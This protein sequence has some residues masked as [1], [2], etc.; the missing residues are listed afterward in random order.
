MAASSTPVPVRDHR[1]AVGD[2]H[3]VEQADAEQELRIERRS[4][5][6]A[7]RESGWSDPRREMAVIA[8]VSISV[9]TSMPNKRASGIEL[10]GQAPGSCRCRSRFPARWRRRRA[11]RPADQ[12]VAA[13][14]IIPPR[15]VIDVTLPAVHPVH[16]AGRFGRP[17]RDQRRYPEEYC[18]HRRTS[19]CWCMTHSLAA[20]S[21]DKD[22][23]GGH[24]AM[25]G[26][27]SNCSV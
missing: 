14:Q 22:V 10:G 23:T 6:H 12:L 1:E 17:R 25:H 9:E 8:E 3:M 20:C 24:R 21:R 16:A 15:S 5:R 11:C 4:H 27:S 2:H 26:M 18:G 13:E 7:R 19:Y